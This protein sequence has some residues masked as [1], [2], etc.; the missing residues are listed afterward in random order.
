MELKGSTKHTMHLEI[1][2]LF[3]T[4]WRHVRYVKLIREYYI[5]CLDIIKGSIF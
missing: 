2:K 1:P 4:E 3:F 5:C